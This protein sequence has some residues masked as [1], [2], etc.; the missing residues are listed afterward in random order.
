M[1][2]FTSA[3]A[4]AKKFLVPAFLVRDAFD[5]LSAVTNY[6][7]PVLIVHGKHDEII[8][9]SHAITLHKAAK[10]GK[11]IAYDAGH[12]DCPPDWDVFWRDIASFLKSAGII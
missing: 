12:N 1:S 11:I 4:F 6:P 8:P 7:A 3:R 2:A 9:F 5:N 10:L